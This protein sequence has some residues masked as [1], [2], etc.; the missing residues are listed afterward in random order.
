LRNLGVYTEIIECLDLLAKPARHQR[1]WQHEGPFGRH[2]FYDT[3]ND[4]YTFILDPQSRYW[5]SVGDVV[6][7]LAE[8]R[9]CAEVLEE[10]DV[11]L[12]AIGRR[13]SDKVDEALAHEHWPAVVA[14]AQ[15]ALQVMQRAQ[16]E[17]PEPLEPIGSPQTTP[18]MDF[19]A[20]GICDWVDLAVCVIAL[21][22]RYPD[23]A[24]EPLQDETLDVL[25]RLLEAGLMEAGEVTADADPPF[26][27]W[28]LAT[29]AVLERVRREWDS[30]ARAPRLGE[31]C[32]L[33]DTE[34][35]RSIA[36]SQ[37]KEPEVP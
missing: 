6:Y 5:T 21:A 33:R 32:S 12:D 37:A 14:A 9:A 36:A 15:R 10:L 4:L 7:T 29:S 34:A 2:D 26:K 11:V 24:A 22:S 16:A 20:L 13:E 1:R 18:E 3:V 25:G 8:A 31:V 19:L 30:L 35:G 27:P 23:L 17:H 28:D